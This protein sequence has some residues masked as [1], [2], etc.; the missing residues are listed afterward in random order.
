[1]ILGQVDPLASIGRFDET[2]IN[3]E[4]S[5]KGRASIV[6]V[7]L[8]DFAVF[9]EAAGVD[10][11]GFT[12]QQFDFYNSAILWRIASQYKSFDIQQKSKESC[13]QDDYRTK[14]LW[15]NNACDMLGMINAE[16]RAQAGFCDGKPVDFTD[17]FTAKVMDFKCKKFN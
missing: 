6:D 17:V 14:A 7:V 8:F 16:L 5:N 15:S 9:T 13:T 11:S 3:N 1:M 2:A 4:M 12:T 10:T